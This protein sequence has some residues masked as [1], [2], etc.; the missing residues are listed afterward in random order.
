L[1]GSAVLVVLEWVYVFHSRLAMND[2]ELPDII[3]ALQA[4]D[5]D[6]ATPAKETE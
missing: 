4:V 6:H 1:A 2:E 3:A 5:T